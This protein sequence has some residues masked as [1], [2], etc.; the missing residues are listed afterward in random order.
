MTYTAQLLHNWRCLKF[1]YIIKQIQKVV[2]KC[3]ISDLQYMF[4]IIISKLLNYSSIYERVIV[5]QMNREAIIV[6]FL[7]VKFDDKEKWWLHKSI[8]S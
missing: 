1:N 8:P 5:N 6:W 3:L 4:N 2:C 7:A